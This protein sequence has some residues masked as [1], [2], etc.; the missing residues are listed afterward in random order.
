MNDI[1]TYLLDGP[2]LPRPCVHGA[3][4]CTT[5]HDRDESDLSGVLC[6]APIAL[7]EAQRPGAVEQV[8]GGRWTDD[9]ETVPLVTL[10]SGE[11]R[12]IAELAPDS[13]RR[14][15]VALLAAADR[16]EVTG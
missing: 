6:D 11:M 15:A 10:L 14:L 3:P 2:E 9:V 1:V 12:E 4:G 7:I 5:D 13:A 16:A 8:T